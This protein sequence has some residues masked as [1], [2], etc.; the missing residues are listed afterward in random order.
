MIAVLHK[1][2]IDQESEQTALRESKNTEN[3]TAAA[4]EG[5]LAPLGGNG[6]MSYLKIEP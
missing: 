1:Q 6:R 3:A 2:Y 5:A 4:I